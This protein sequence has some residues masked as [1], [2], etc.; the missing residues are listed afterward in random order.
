MN[1]E[2]DSRQKRALEAAAAAVA[3]ER[4]YGIPGELTMAQWALESAWGIKAPGNNCFGIKATASTP[5]GQRQTLQTIEYLTPKEMQSPAWR[6][7]VVRALEPSG[8]RI[9]C[10]V[11]D[12]FRVFPTI[13]DCFDAYGQLLTAGRY[14]KP[15][16][17]RYL[18]H[19]N[20]TQFFEELEGKD[21]QPPYATAPNY[22]NTLLLV[23]KSP[24]IVDGL[25]AARRA[26][27][28]TEVSS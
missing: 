16:F 15:R 27:Q 17:E 23:A 11:Q 4:K 10:V 8:K 22:A 14:F 2:Q 25:N 19:K 24:F 5:A 18:Q 12:D 21:G 1:T 3:V 7:K 20:L 6:N 13:G 28:K 26:S 9:Q